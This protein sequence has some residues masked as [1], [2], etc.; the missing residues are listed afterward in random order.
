MDVWLPDPGDLVA[1][2]RFL[3]ELMERLRATPG[4][5]RVGGVSSFP[6]RSEGSANGTFLVL[7]RPDEVTSFDD[8]RRIGR[9]PERS[10]NAEYRVA[11][12][13]YF[14]AMGIPLLRGRLFD[15][16]DAPDGPHAALISESLARTQWPGQDPLGRLI[17]FGNMDGDL[18]PFTVVGVVGDVRDRGV[19]APPRP[20]LYGYYRQRPKWTSSFYLAIQG[21]LDAAQ[22]IAQAREIARE[23]DPQVPT[24]FQTLEDVV[25]T[26]LADRRFVLSLLA[27]FGALALLLAT[28]GVYG[29]VAYV[30]SERTSEMGV[31]MALGARREDVVRLLVRRGAV[32]AVAGI[33]VGLAASLAAT[34]VLKNF[35]YGVGAADPASLGATCLVLLVAALAASWVPARRASRLD[36]VRALRQE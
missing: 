13:D 28:M 23:L 20:T 12:R 14:G 31:R 3:Q 6:L 36:P 24:R 26:S 33:G 4:V 10:G 30:A 8:W 22:A 34:R 18:H 11:S 9:Q 17:Q 32:L 2:S 7:Q 27:L 21:R 35:L 1:R 15:E 16:T 5:A 25:S 29:V 19:G